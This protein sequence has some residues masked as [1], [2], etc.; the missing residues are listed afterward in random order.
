MGKNLIVKYNLL[1]INKIM[2]E[3]N[4][5][6]KKRKKIAIAVIV[7]VLLCSSFY[8]GIFFAKKT[9][10][11]DKLINKDT[12]FL[13]N[14]LNKYEVEKRNNVSQDVDFSLFWDVW[15]MLKLNYVDADNIKDKELFYGA[16]RGMVE[17]AGDPYTVFMNPVVTKE[18]NDD[19]AGTFE[20]I[21]AEIGIKDGVLTIVSPLTDMPAQKAGL[22][23]GDKILA[24]NGQDSSGVL[25]DEAVAKIR[26]E[27]GTDVTLTIW[28]DSFD[29][30][31]DFVI[32]RGTIVVKSV[33]WNMRDDDIMLIEISHFN[34]DT[35][36]LFERAV[37]DVLTKKPKGIILDLR[38]NPGGFLDTAI[39]VASEWVDEGVIVS[40]KKSDDSGNDYL[41][42]G[43]ARL[44]EYR[45]VVLVNEGSASA[46]EIV[47]GA[48]KDY[49]KAT[50]I[51]MRTFGKG[52]VQELAPLK[53]GSSLKVTVA[54]W[55]TPKGINI[56]DEGIIPDEEIDLTDEDY[57]TDKDPQMDKAIE[58]ITQ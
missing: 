54:K 39:E 22:K 32:T 36:D 33:K 9:E 44:A 41:A 35:E 30:P 57:S 12:V 15:D 49:E 40:E 43:R 2:M 11:D 24:I 53:D 7:A 25:I 16:I 14:I 17:A 46:S 1:F 29:S 45:T 6:H 56:S 21:G 20:G 23:P 26:G 38:N 10:I 31:Q 3:F 50:I 37:S 51:G 58:I 52:S 8:G 28:R 13:G 18:F 55:L 27:K 34:S 5:Q 48:L 47:S 19:L 4:Q 42:R